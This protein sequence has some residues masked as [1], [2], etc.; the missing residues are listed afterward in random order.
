LADTSRGRPFVDTL[1]RLWDEHAFENGPLWFAQALLIFAVGVVAWSTFHPVS[2]P[3]AEPASSLP[4]PRPWPS[5]TALA[6]AAACTGLA[7]LALRQ[8]WPV[9]VNVWGLQL[10]Y[11]ASYV[12]LFAFGVAAAGPRW[13]ERVSAS[14]ARLW[15]R[16]ACVAFPI[17]PVA[18]FMAKGLPALA[19][20]PIDALYA[21]WEPLVSWGIILTLLRRFASGDRPVGRYEQRLGRRA[22]AMYIVHAP[23]LVAIALAWRQVH[24]PQLVKFAVTGSLTCVSC[25]VLAG[26]LVRVVGVRRIV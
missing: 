26:M 6:L 3:C 7:A 5:N 13:L 10:G 8:V 23:V 20:R 24:A 15:R 17:L 2:R 25:Y 1:A 18:Y 14:Q 9:G 16:I 4:Q 11:F 19:G 12:L 21:F 22:Y